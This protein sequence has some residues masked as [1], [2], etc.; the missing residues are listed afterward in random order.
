MSLRALIILVCLILCC[1]DHSAWA[2]SDQT[3]AR[4]LATTPFDAQYWIEA[5][6]VQ[7][8]KGRALIETV[9]EAASKTVIRIFGDPVYGDLNHDGIT[10]AAL[11]L[12][13]TSGGSGTFYFVAAAINRDGRYEGTEAVF[14][15]DRIAPEALLIGHSLVI[16]DYKDR[17][18]GE[19]MVA[20]PGVDRSM[21]LLFDSQGF[22]S[23]PLENGEL[24]IAGEVVIGDEVRAVHPCGVAEPSWLLGDSPALPTMQM[25]YHLNMSDAS[26]YAPLFMIIT[27]E[28]APS[29]KDGYGTDYSSAIRAQKLV[30]IIPGKTCGQ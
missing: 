29:P 4:Q 2:D 3:P 25:A 10:D 12:T 11:L 21:Y 27:G 17:Q 14:L 1:G 6:A 23:I 7:L 20:E 18:S 16:V 5:E 28:L 24:V 30:K 22:R 9:P 19:P 13:R 15:G 8:N 26:P